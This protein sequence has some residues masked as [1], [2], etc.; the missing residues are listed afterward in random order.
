MYK[1]DS[2]NRIENTYTDGEIEYKVKT[3]FK[4]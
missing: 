2:K 1:W 4:K 3:R